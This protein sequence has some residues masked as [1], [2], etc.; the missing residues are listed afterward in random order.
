[1]QTITPSLRNQKIAFF[2]THQ[3]FLAEIISALSINNQVRL[4]EG[5][6][7]E[8]MA[9]L[10]DWADI[11]W[12]EWCDALLI[13]A[14]HLPQKCKIV[15]RLHSYEAFTDMPSHVDWSK[16]DSLIFVNDSVRQLFEQQVSHETRASLPLAVI[17]NGVDTAKFVIPHSK[18]LTKKIA[19]VG[20]INYKKNPTLLLYCFKKIHEYDPGYSLYIAGSHQ[21]PRIELYFQHFLQRNPLPIYFDGWIDDMPQ[22]Y[23]D[24]SFVISTSLFESFHYSIAEGMSCGLIPLIHDWYGADLLYPNEFLYSDP[25]DCLRLLQTIE[26]SDT[27][28]TA[29]DNR[30]FIQQRYSQNDK[31]REIEQLLSQLITPGRESHIR[32]LQ[33][34]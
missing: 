21:D 9:A 34:A 10:L 4:F 20:Y 3:M 16:V 8:R 15:C 25:D 11:A 2:A 12:F 27:A 33:T 28:Q 18:V 32:E 29:C 31:V 26:K 14:T 19:S 1:M 24:K 5:T 7:V 23:R 13:Q 30:K 22:W 17:H 6:T